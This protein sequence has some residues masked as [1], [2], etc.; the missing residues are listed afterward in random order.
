MVSEPIRRVMV[1]NVVGLTPGM[2]G[3]NTPHLARLAQDGFM[4]PLT[5]VFPAVTCTVQAS[6]L[7]G[8]PPARHGIVANGWF[9]RELNEILFWKQSNQLIQ[10]ETVY[11]A[12]RARWPGHRTAKMFWWYNMYAPVDWSLTPR[13]SYPADGRKIPDV[14]SEP[15]QLLD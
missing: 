5:T 2:I 9:F 14:Y 12:A 11:A 4:R 6:L 8:L 15:P 1:I 3:A 7:T 10:G 13:P